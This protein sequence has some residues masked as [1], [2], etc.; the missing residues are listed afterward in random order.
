M[1]V[2]DANKCRLETET[3]SDVPEITL[4]QRGQ[5]VSVFRS[6]R[7][8]KRK[9]FLLL[10]VAACSSKH[11]LSETFVQRRR[12]N[13]SVLFLLPRDIAR[14]RFKWGETETGTRFVDK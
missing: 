4:P 10:L 3:E 5:R 14:F 9:N 7:G 11:Q 8:G 1:L 2:L 13:I 6:R 12:S